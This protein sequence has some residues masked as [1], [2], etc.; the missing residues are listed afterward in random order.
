M[1]S[2]EKLEALYQECVEC[3]ACK[4]ITKFK[5]RFKIDPK[6]GYVPRGFYFKNVPVKFLLV[7][8]NPGTPAKK[9]EAMVKEFVSTGNERNLSKGYLLYTKR[10]FDIAKKN[11]FKADEKF[12]SDINRTI[13]QENLEYH[14]LEN[15]TLGMENTF[16]D[17]LVRLFT[18]GFKTYFEKTTTDVFD[19]CA[20]TNF[21]KCSSIE[22]DMPAS[23]FPRDVIKNCVN[24]WLRREIE[25]LRPQ[26]VVFLGMGIHERYR[27]LVNAKR[28]ST[29]IEKLNVPL[30]ERLGHVSRRYLRKVNEKDLGDI[31]S[32]FKDQET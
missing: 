25:I 11:A 3:R 20:Y 16:N 10:M 32:A 13:K 14:F 1:T 26:V 8:Q 2:K 18:W 5:E 4:G 17:E 7:A 23:K 31:L 12:V 29:R 28:Q 6:T 22:K 21:V 24:N 9:E 19:F 30:V 15:V 27:K